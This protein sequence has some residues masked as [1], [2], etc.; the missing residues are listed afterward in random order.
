MD[1]KQ[2]LPISCLQETH[3]RCKES[4]SLKVKGMKKIFHANVN[5]KKPG[6]AM[7]ISDKVDFKTK[8][9]IRAKEEHHIMIKG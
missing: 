2:D 3:F 6:I 4:H 7:L 1:K 8:T 5:Q 9:V